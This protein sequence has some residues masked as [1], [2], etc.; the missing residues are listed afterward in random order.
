[1]TWTGAAIV[2]VGEASLGSERDI[3]DGRYADSF[4]VFDR[5]NE[6]K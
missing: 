5:K 1:M 2:D 3:T 4:E 6:Q